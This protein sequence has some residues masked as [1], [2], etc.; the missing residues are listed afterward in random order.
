ME[1]STND[2]FIDEKVLNEIDE[3]YEQSSDSL[4]D[5]ESKDSGR[6]TALIIRRDKA[7]LEQQYINAQSF[8]K[9][10]ETSKGESFIQERNLT[11]KENEQALL[12][13]YAN[14]AGLFLEKALYEEE[15]GDVLVLG[16]AYSSKENG[17]EDSSSTDKSLDSEE[18][19]FERNTDSNSIADDKRKLERY[20]FQFGE[21]LTLEPEDDEILMNSGILSSSELSSNIQNDS[22]ELQEIATS[23]SLSHDSSIAENEYYDFQMFAE[24]NTEKYISDEEEYKSNTFQTRELRTSESEEKASVKKLQ[25]E[26]QELFDMLVESFATMD[27]I[28]TEVDET[29]DTMTRDNARLKSISEIYRSQAEEI[30]HKFEAARNCTECNESDSLELELADAKLLLDESKLLCSTLEQKLNARKQK[31][32]AREKRYVSEIQALKH[33]L[34][35][36]CKEHDRERAVSRELRLK[37]IESSS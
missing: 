18:V 2:D 31:Y 3:A 27:M 21:F 30:R 5:S 1:S 13:S 10:S 8:L 9:N 15:N 7:R 17:S 28:V 34:N 37:L 16:G 32:D 6:L 26:N 23:F 12:N 25:V 33:D 29:I 24:N 36:I 4:S 11:V 22:Q 19:V 35:R 20:A 14:E